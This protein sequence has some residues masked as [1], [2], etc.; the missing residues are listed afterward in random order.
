MSQTFIIPVTNVPQTF[1]IPLAGN[2][3]IMT[4]YWNDAPDAGWVFDLADAVT[5]DSI[6]A[7]IPFVTGADLLSGLDYLGIDGSLVVYTDGDPTAVPTLDNLG[8]DCN[9]YFIT[10]AADG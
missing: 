10:D 8:V 1:E 7:G 3:Y 2:N 4:V 5:N 6:I 9:L